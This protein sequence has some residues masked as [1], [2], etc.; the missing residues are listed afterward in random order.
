MDEQKTGPV[1]DFI[2]TGRQALGPVGPVGPGG[3][4]E[5]AAASRRAGPAGHWVVARSPH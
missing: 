2:P 4:V 1:R 3:P 5:T